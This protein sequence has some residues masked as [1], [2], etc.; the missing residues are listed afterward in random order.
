[1][2][3]LLAYKGVPVIMD[4]LL[5]QPRHSLIRQS[6]KARELDEPLNG[7]GFG[8][9]WY[10]PD[11]DP[12]PAVFVSTSPAWSNRN[13]RLLAPKIRS[14]CILA[15]VRAASFGDISEANC[16]PFY[17]QR[18]L[19]M[20]NGG[21][22]GFERIKRP[23]RRSLSD[24][25]YSWIKGQ[26]DSEH[27]FALVLENLRP[28]G[29]GYTVQDLAGAVEE[30]VVRLKV[31]RRRARTNGTFYLNVVL[32]DGNLLLAARYVSHGRARPLTL[33]YSEGSRYVCEEGVCLMERC[34]P[35]S[36]SV[37]VASERLTRLDSDWQEV[38][39]NHF[40]LV[41]GDGS[42]SLQPIRA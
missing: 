28:S 23:L 42:V 32:T 29:E 39:R 26:T 3:R 11:I 15:H 36:R 20:H 30:A 4:Q 22:E 12:T 10:V 1:M 40:L 33:Y 13:L 19:F 18:F 31:L 14:H 8:V 21:I 27:F 35:A 37:I 6:Y 25:L 34:H 38:P 5:Y 41:E 2:C 24:E 9:G 16:H 17:Y 7:D